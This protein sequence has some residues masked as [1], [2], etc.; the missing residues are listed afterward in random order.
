MIRPTT[1]WRRTGWRNM[2]SDLTVDLVLVASCGCT[3]ARLGG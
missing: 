1:A 2:W 3:T